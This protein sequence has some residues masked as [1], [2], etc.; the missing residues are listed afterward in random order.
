VT[1]IDERTGEV[2]GRSAPIG[3]DL[4]GLAVGGGSVWVTR[5]EDDFLFRLDAETMQ[6]MGVPASVGANPQGVAVSGTTAW[7]AN[8]ASDSVTRVDF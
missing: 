2:I 3:G 7:V 5:A 8:Q 6:P 4:G 1:K